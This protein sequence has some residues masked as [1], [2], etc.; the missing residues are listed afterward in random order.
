MKK[1]PVFDIKYAT[2]FI[3]IEENGLVLVIPYFIIRG[4]RTSVHSF[5][6]YCV[7]QKTGTGKISEAYKWEERMAGHGVS[8]E[9]IKKIRKF[10]ETANK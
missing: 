9:L 7:G 4:Y 2:D 1:F 3:P 5:E 8:L 6:E 10:L